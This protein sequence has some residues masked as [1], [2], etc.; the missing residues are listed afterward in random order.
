[1]GIVPPDLCSTFISIQYNN[2]LVG[3]EMHDA[4]RNIYACTCTYTHMSNSPCTHT[5]L[6]TTFIT[7]L[8][9][10]VCPSCKWRFLTYF[11]LWS[12]FVLT[13]YLIQVSTGLFNTSFS[14]P[15][16]TSIPADNTEHK[17]SSHQLSGTH[18]ENLLDSFCVTRLLTPLSLSLPPP[19][20]TQT[21]NKQTNHNA[22]RW[23]W[24]S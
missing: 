23:R 19:S 5:A 22:H 2:Q 6:C 17:V 21:N 18:E 20:Y 1:M 13:L 16:A 7:T 24:P 4:L 14:I 9:V 15:R 10:H 12:V 11:I 8:H 3:T